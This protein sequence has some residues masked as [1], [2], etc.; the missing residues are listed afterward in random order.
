MNL[1]LALALILLS[2]VATAKS[3]D[4]SN[5]GGQLSGGN[6]GLT[7]SGSTLVAIFPSNGTPLQ[8]NLGTISFMTSARASGN[9]QQGATFGTG[10]TFTITGNGTGGIP[11]GVIFTGTFDTPVLWSLITLSNGTHN[12]TL[13]GTLTGTWFTGKAVSGVTVQLTINTGKGFFNGKTLISSGDTE[14]VGVGGV[15]RGVVPEPS[16]LMMMG[17]GLVGLASLA[18]YKLKIPF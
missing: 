7:L 5:Q 16:S 11:N 3:V 10:G 15:T 17:T 12:Y 6:N 4:F 14:I 18:K 1:R 13:T 8:G 9:L 2:T